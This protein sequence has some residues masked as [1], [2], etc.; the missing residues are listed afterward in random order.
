MD[1][2][3]SQ[4]SAPDCFEAAI[5]D[6]YQILGV[7]LLPL[8]IGRYRLLKRFGCGF[9]ADQETKV[10][11]PDLLLGILICS[12]PCREFLSELA[13]DGFP[14]MIRRWARVIRAA[15]PWWYRIFPIGALRRWWLRNHSFNFIQK[16]QLFQ[17]YIEDAQRTPHF[18]PLTNASDSWSHWSTNVE[19]IVR[20]EFNWSSEEIDES[21]LSKALADYFQWLEREGHIVILTDEDLEIG[22][23]NAAALEAFIAKNPQLS[24]NGEN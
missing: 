21:P 23:E 18:I 19:G 24:T 16:I 17:R 15:P 5:P 6:P 7:E 11:I 4:S 20:S 10:G 14:K 9:V 8:S 13:T 12:M 1:K 22:R 2:A 3:S